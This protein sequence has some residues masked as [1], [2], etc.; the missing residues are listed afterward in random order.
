MWITAGLVL[1]G[2]ICGDFTLGFLGE[3]S[4]EVAVKNHGDAH[5]QFR[6]DV[7]ATENVVHVGAVAVKFACEPRHGAFLIL[8]FLLDECANENGVFITFSSSCSFL[9]GLSC[10]SLGFFDLVC[11]FH[12]F[13]CLVALCSSQKMWD[14][15]LRL[16]VPWKNLLIS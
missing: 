14:Y 3:D 11:V 6:I 8:K 16:Q 10:A 15:Y 9:S 13:D 5:Q 12:F 4:E 2:R 1:D 7:L